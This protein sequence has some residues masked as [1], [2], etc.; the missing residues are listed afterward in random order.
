MPM[1]NYPG[2][3]LITGNGGGGFASEKY[4]T[5]IGGSPQPTSVGVAIAK[6]PPP[7]TTT[8]QT[9]TYYATSQAFEMTCIGLKPFTVHNFYFDNIDQGANCK[10]KGGILGG[11]LKSD[12]AGLLYFTFLYNSGLPSTSTDATAQQATIN[13]LAGTKTVLVRNSDNTSRCTET[14]NVVGSY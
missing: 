13:R 11:T 6:D 10:P 12:G 5:G 4:D 9:T 14:I 8:K 3:R 7:P 1:N 2:T